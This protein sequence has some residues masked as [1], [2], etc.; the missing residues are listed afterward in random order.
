VSAT[1]EE[2]KARQEADAKWDSE[3]RAAQAAAR[4]G[5]TPTQERALRFC[6]QIAVCVSATDLLREE[7]SKPDGSVEVTWC[8]ASTWPHAGDAVSGVLATVKPSDCGW[9]W[10]ATFRPKAQVSAAQLLEE[11]WTR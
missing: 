2:V 4:A 10:V 9:F 6:E 5:M 3:Y 8:G 7:Y 1:Y 11:E